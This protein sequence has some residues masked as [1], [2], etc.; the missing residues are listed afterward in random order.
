MLLASISAVIAV[1]TPA[2]SA[3]NAADRAPSPVMAVA[4]LVAESRVPWARVP[5]A[6]PAAS[7][8]AALTPARE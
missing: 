3:P 6:W 7:G 4:E 8:Q 2:T 1:L 5:K